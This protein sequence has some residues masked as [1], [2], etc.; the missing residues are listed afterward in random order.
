LLLLLLLR[1]WHQP[2]K[3]VLLELLALLLLLVRVVV[4]VV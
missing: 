3:D 4:V 2:V 1:M